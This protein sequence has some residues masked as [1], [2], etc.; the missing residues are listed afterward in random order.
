MTTSAE[1]PEQDASPT[2]SAMTDS[3]RSADQIEVFFDGACPIC[4][5]EVSWLQRM[6]R[7][8]RLRPIDIAAHDFAPLEFGIPMSDFMAEIHARLPN[9]TWVTGVE[10]FRQVYA[11]I[12][13]GRLAGFAR[14]P[15]IRQLLDVAYRLFA[16]NRL[17]LTGRCASHDRSLCE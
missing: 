12:G 9:G 3:E 10:V 8:T 16:K 2:V 7:R 14:L 4:R 17:R 15:G 5:R 1:A 13:F 6:D 11:A